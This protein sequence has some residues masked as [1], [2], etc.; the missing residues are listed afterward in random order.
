[1][2]HGDPIS[3]VYFLCSSREFGRGASYRAQPEVAC[4]FLIKDNFLFTKARI[5]EQSSAW[6]GILPEID[7]LNAIGD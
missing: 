2:H 6:E 1:M 5:Y 7:S 4:D 3:W